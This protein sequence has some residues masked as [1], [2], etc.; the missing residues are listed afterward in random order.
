MFNNFVYK[1]YSAVVAVGVHATVGGGGSK[2]QSVSTSRNSSTSYEYSITFDYEF[3][4]SSDPFTAGHAS[5]IIVGGGV[6]LVVSQ[7]IQGLIVY[8]Y[9]L[10]DL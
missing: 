1:G 9:Y 2:Q 6:D 7:A 3:S 8:T 10:I 5:D 4:T